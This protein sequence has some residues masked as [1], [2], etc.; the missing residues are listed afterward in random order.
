MPALRFR[1]GPSGLR[2][3]AGVAVLAV[4]GVVWTTPGP[5]AGEGTVVFSGTAAASGV[6]LR[7]TM[8]G[9]PVSDTPI[10]GGGPTAQVQLDSIG[11]STGYA[12]FPDPGGILL[13]GPTTFTGLLAGGVGPLPPVTFPAPPPDYPFYV[14]SN[15]ATAP[16]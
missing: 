2:R 9:A 16:Q 3:L 1:P 14:Q 8:P 11:N 5:A 4:P 13:T 12:S 15:S 10:D 6:Q 7:M